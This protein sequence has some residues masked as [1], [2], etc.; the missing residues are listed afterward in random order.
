MHSVRSRVCGGAGVGV[1]TASR[2]IGSRGPVA[3]GDGAG[4]STSAE[5]SLE[6]AVRADARSD[7]DGW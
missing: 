2:V 7:S 3:L 6:T 1:A 4:A 5:S